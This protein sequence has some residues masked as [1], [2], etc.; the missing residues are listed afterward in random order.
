MN[1]NHH[2]LLRRERGGAYSYKLFHARAL[3]SYDSWRC[4]LISKCFVRYWQLMKMQVCHSLCLHSLCFLCFSW[5]YCVSYMIRYVSYYSHVSYVKIMFLWWVHPA[6]SVY[7][8]IWLAILLCP[9]SV[10]LPHCVRGRRN[11]AASWFSC[12]SPQGICGTPQHSYTFFLRPLCAKCLCF[13]ALFLALVPVLCVW[14]CVPM[15][16]HIWSRL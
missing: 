4:D 7:V 1:L 6:L 5:W 10:V 11:F 15:V 8:N 12:R 16:S 13:Y 14:P 9:G 2:R 3:S